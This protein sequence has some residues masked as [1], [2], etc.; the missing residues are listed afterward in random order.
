ME[1]GCN[2][3]AA[4]GKGNDNSENT[5]FRATLAYWYSLERHRTEGEANREKTR[6]SSNDSITR[7]LP[8]YNMHANKH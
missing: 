3:A 5:M 8:T 6:I 7:D 4:I 1:K 2:L